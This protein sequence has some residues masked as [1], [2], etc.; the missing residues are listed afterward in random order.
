MKLSKTVLQW[1][2]YSRNDLS[3]AKATLEL[4]KNYRNGAAFLA[5]QSAEKIIKAYLTFKKVRVPKTHDMELL[6][7][8]V[9]KIDLILS[10]KII[11][12]KTLTIYAVTYRYPD[13]EKRPLTVAKVKAAIKVADLVYSSCLKDISG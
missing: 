8:E 6:I 9:S 3:M 10:K 4:S 7:N 12:A 5:Q 1:I 11:K 2:K 13:A